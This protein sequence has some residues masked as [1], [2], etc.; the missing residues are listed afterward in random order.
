MHQALPSLPCPS[1]EPCDPAGQPHG[2][3]AD[4]ARWLESLTE[5]VKMGPASPRSCCSSPLASLRFFELQFSVPCCKRTVSPG[6]ELWL[7]Q[8]VLG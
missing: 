8:Q 4:P 3:P 5:L 1:R 2:H 6:Q 7:C